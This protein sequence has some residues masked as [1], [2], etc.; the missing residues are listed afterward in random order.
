MLMGL[1]G[2]LTSS[3]CEAT[4]NS[5]EIYKAC[6]CIGRNSLSWHLVNT[7]TRLDITQIKRSGE[8]LLH[9]NVTCLLMR[10]DIDLPNIDKNEFQWKPRDNTQFYHSHTEHCTLLYE[11]E[12]TGFCQSSE[13]LCTHGNKTVQVTHRRISLER[14]DFFL[15]ELTI[16]TKSNPITAHCRST[17][18]DSFKFTQ[19]CKIINANFL[20][21]HFCVAY[22]Y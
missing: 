14:P 15:F 3:Q 5:V 13:L 16:T 22:K 9:P 19:T 1:F 20:T 7:R 11:W 17:P 6:G 8:V 12:C 18:S 10:I 21:F 2:R 4:S